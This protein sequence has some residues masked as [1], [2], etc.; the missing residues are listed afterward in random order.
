L[1]ASDGRIVQPKTANFET[2]N[3]LLKSESSQRP[4]VLVVSLRLTLIQQFW[5]LALLNVL[6]SAAMDKKKRGSY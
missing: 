3:K 1:G 4:S 6:V 5:Y 2:N